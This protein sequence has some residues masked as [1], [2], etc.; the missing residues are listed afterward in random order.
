MSNSVEG[1]PVSGGEGAFR[2]VDV[3]AA[4]N[5]GLQGSLASLSKLAVGQLTLEETMIQV[6]LFA[7]WAVPGADGAG[8]TLLEK[9]SADTIVAT[10]AFVSEIDAVQYGLGQGPCIT[11]A[12]KGQTTM[13]RSLGADE[14]WPQFGSKIA[15]MGIHSALSLPLITPGG[16]VGAINIYAHAEDV[17]DVRAAALG[18]SYAKPAA[19]AVQNA[20]VLAGVRRVAEQL[21]SALAGRGVIERAVGIM[22][23]RSGG[24]AEEAMAR[25][26]TLSAN[27]HQEM[28]QVAQKIVD[29]AVRRAEVRHQG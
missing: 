25:L 17:F 15:Q 23:S 7:V 20:H 10:A 28:P 6:A 16:V 22:L 9:D 12:A 8:L 5:A 24:T 2:S 13:S 27:E 11:A 4:E 3:R 19:I 18:E 26:R 1:E 14:R 29:E 21:H